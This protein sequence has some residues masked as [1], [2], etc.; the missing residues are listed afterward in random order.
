VKKK[1]FV[2]LIVVAC[3]CVLL[4]HVDL[5]QLGRV[6]LDVQPD[7]LAL[8]LSAQ[9]IIIWIKSIRWAIAI[10]GATDRPVRRALSA[11]II[12]F[13]GNVLLPARFGELLRVGIIEKHNQIGWSVALTTLGLM[14][15]F[16]LLSLAG[17]F[18][19]VSMWAT[20]LLATHRWEVALLG[21]LIAS[22]LGI[23]VAVQHKAA[24]LNAVLL[25][26]HQ[27]LPDALKR[28]FTRYT[29]LFVQGLSVLGKRR[30]LGSVLLMTITVWGLETASTYLILH[31]FHINATLPMAVMLVVV[32]N[33]SFAIPITPGNI[34]VSQAISVFL[35]GTF[36]VTPPY[37]LAY[38]IGAQGASQLL[39]FSLGML[40]LYRE[41]M[42]LNL[43]RQRSA[44]LI[45]VPTSTME[46]HP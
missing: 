1:I 45:N 11:S 19:L 32:L 22:T 39:I 17:Y 15:L 21:T 2:G 36:G 28:Y 10:R 7:F 26:I 18:L 31:A 12:G 35:L 24:L 27:V 20:S 30:L 40:C 25:P 13:A 14:Q 5:R 6:L 8:G 29:E 23:L 33:F 9:L 41:G 4:H 37:A 38:S 46:I 44:E 16:D 42:S 43:F 34:G 3:L